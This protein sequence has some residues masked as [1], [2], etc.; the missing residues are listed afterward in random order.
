MMRALAVAGVLGLCVTTS[1]HDHGK[2]HDHSEAHPSGHNHHAEGHGHHDGPVVSLTLWS[3]QFEVFAEHPPASAGKKIAF[4]VHVTTLD[5]FKSVNDGTA[6][7]QFDG[8]ATLSSAA[9]KPVR[10]GIFRIELTPMTRGEYRGRL[11]VDGK[12]SG[13]VEN[14]NMK[15][16]ATAKEAA[17]SVKDESDDG[18]V[19]FL[20]EQQWR[21]PFGTEF[22]KQGTIVPATEVA[23]RIDTPPGGK[24][25]VSAQVTGRLVAPRKGLARP[26]DV[27]KKGQLLAALL[28]A[29]SS[30][31]NAA[32]AQL[33]IAEAQARSSAA[34][35]ALE[36]A[37]RLIKDEAIAQREFE[38]AQREVRVAKSAVFAARR[39]AAIYAG[40]SGHGRG[41]TWRL[42]API[43]GII[44][45]VNATPGA[46]V[47]PGKSLFSIV[48]TKELWIV[49]RIPEQQA[50]RLRI[51]R[52]AS[53]KLAGLDTWKPI[54]IGGKDA[55]GSVI[56][57]GRLVDPVRRTVDLIYAVRTP[58][59]A[60]RVGGLVKVGIPVGD[61]FKG[62]VIPLSALIDKQG[63]HVVY[64]QV[65][66]EH[67]QERQV[68]VGPRAGG[69]VGIVSGIKVGERIVTTGA[70]L[71]RLADGA[72]NSQAHGHIH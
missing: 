49:A 10:P 47:S 60:M 63:R 58:D 24:A 37:K 70:H 68:R 29:P 42:T 30:P 41:G 14:F 55:T 18:L 31:E 20:K 7:L 25:E 38:A 21:V 72:K 62:I 6:T 12:V 34:R 61:E 56:T 23:G 3:D 66:G 51:K 16:F 50:A 65:D 22:T 64:V 67:F 33:A 15:V 1:C 44:T 28:P 9:A 48:D 13:T 2:G 69:H 43:G 54:V 19:E 57:L 40:A 46:T 45:S 17:A 39:A 5:G 71:I 52:N 8:A 35:T 4:L 36:R 32:R 11:R 53:Y 27:V 59:P 26:G